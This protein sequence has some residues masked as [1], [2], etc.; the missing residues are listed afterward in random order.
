MDEANVNLSFF[1]T[2]KKSGLTSANFNKYSIKC[3]L[4]I[5]VSKYLVIETKR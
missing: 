1:L 3:L 4:Y 5:I 2:T